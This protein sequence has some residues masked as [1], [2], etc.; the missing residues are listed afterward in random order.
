MRVSQGKRSTRKLTGQH[1]VA[2]RNYVKHVFFRSSDSVILVDKFLKLC[3][4]A[5]KFE[6]NKGEAT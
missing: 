5:Q 4:L 2:H 6:N 3:C 1:T